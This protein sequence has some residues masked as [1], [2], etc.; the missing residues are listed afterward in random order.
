MRIRRRSPYYDK[1]RDAAAVAS[2]IFEGS[3]MVN[4]AST[5]G[6]RRIAF[7][8]GAAQGIGRTVALRLA[9]DGLGV[10]VIDLPSKR[11][12]LGDVVSEI[13]DA[14]GQPAIAL[15]GDVS[16]EADMRRMTESAVEHLGGLD[17]VRLKPSLFDGI[18]LG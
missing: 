12:Q 14:Q 6:L 7:V 18:T 8:T 9:R 2:V 11:K 13:K 16:N 17:V 1:L 3:A 4:A 10:A 5:M 15:M